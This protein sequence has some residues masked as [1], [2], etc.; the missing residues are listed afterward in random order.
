MGFTT[1]IFLFV[2]FPAALLF[3]S[4]AAYLESAPWSCAAMKKIRLRD[5]TLIGFSLCFYGWACFDDMF[6]LCIYIIIVY[7]WARLISAGKNLPK[8][9]AILGAL[10]GGLLLALLFYCK[11]TAFAASIAK[12]WFHV[13]WSLT[14]PRSLLGISFLTFSAVSYL[15]DIC[16]GEAQAGSL[17][18][19]AL[20]LTFFPKLVSGP[21]VL[22]KDFQ[23]QIRTCRMSL[24]AAVKGVNRIMAGFAKK[25]IL[26]DMFGAC[27][28]EMERNAAVGTDVFSAWGGVILY[29]LQI[30]YDFAGY[31]DIAMGTASVLGFEF[32]ENFHFP[33]RSRSISEFWRRWHISLGNWFREYVYIPLGGSRRGERRTLLNLAVVFALTG[34]WHG[35]SWTYILWGAVNG[36][37][38]ILE[39]MLQKKRWYQAVPGAVKW[40]L[41]ACITVMCWELFRFSTLSEFMAWWEMMIG[42]RQFE[43]IQFTWRYY[44]DRQMMV[45][46][47]VGL[48][49]AT[50]AGGARVQEMYRQL[51]E[52]KAG[53]IVQEAVLLGLFV[54]AILCMVNSSYHP[55]IYFQY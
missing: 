51:S 45:L 52:K 7:A 55:F 17:T 48:L 1:V 6:R 46:T 49:G 12:D 5:R 31:S 26:A 19:C 23:P 8:G 36:G 14:E 38:V 3:Y 20:Y 24:D 16:R 39:R 47:V 21:I 43:E 13:T 41:T 27:I 28:L 34:L 22:W 37:F 35:A 40:L 2:Y 53:Y 29:A 11:Y 42:K 18:D 33:Y 32:R 25:L 9:A 50:L 4:A 15:A 44:F 10:G 54:T 30:Y